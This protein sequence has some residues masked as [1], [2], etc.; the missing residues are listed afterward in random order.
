MNKL[1]AL[2]KP[3]VEERDETSDVKQST[4][5]GRRLQRI[6][7]RRS[8]QDNNEKTV[9]T[10]PMPMI[11]S[12]SIDIQRKVTVSGFINESFEKDETDPVDQV[13]ICYIC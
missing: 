2:N 9:E 8:S 10:L 4:A 11:S 7:E 12:K 13:T 1:P 6:R 5:R 3:S